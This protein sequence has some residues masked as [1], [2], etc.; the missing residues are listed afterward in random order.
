MPEAYRLKITLVDSEPEVW[1]QVCVPAQIALSELH[2]IVQRAMG[3]QTLHDYAFRPG[4]GQPPYDVGQSLAAVIAPLQK[5]VLYYTYDFTSGWL[6]RLEA[7]TVTVDHLLPTCED[8]AAA[9][10][11]E[12][13]GGVWGYDELLERLEDPDDPDY[14]DLI[15]KYGDFDPDAFDLADA[16]ARLALLAPGEQLNER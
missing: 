14:L 15:E 16:K 12:G 9:C 2:L 7:Q 11:P 8:G 13:S 1:R 4:V 10:P 3:W 6:H 5:P